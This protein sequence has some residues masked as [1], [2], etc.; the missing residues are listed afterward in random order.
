MKRALGYVAF[1]V[2]VVMASGQVIAQ[3]NPLLG[4]WKLNVAK[5][6]YIGSPAPKEMTRTVEA[7]GDSVKYTYAGTAAD[8]SSIS[9]GFTVK[10]DG[11][12]YPMTGSA[13]GGVDMIAIKR[14]NA[15]TYEATQK[16]GGKVV[17]NTKVEVSKDGKVTTITANSAVDSSHY[18]AVYDKQ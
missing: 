17:A 10:Y 4:T 14:V 2:L 1:V 18:V 8:G 7:D 3:A 11:K 15:N 6:K 16:K 5:S 12:D 13:P 9:Y